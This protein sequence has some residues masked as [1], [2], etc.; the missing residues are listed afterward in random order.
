MASNVIVQYDG[1]FLPDILML[2]QA[3]IVVWFDDTIIVYYYYLFLI[4]YHIV[5]FKEKSVFCSVLFG[6][7]VWRLM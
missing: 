3:P 6:G 4:M 2:T 1:G 7:P 5:F